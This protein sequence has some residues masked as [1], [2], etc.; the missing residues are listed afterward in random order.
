MGNKN[1]WIDLAILDLCTVGLL[2][3]LLRSK[4]VFALPFINYNHLLE[5]HS[6]FTFS[7][8]VTLVLM[9]LMVYELLP[10]S[11][12][13]KPSYQWLFA[14]IAISSWG[15]LIAFILQG[16]G[17]FSIIFSACFILFTY[18]FGWV[19]TRD[20]IKSKSG[21][22]VSLLAISSISCLIISSAGLSVIYYIYFTKSFEAI[23][24]RD[25]LFTYL[26][27]QY[28]GFFSLAIFALLFNHASKNI[29][30]KI[31]KNIHLFSV[32]FCLSIIP[33]L[34]L[35]YLWRDPNELFHAI[36]IGGSILLLLSCIL[37]IISARQFLATY[38]N[39]KPIVRFLAY[40]SM[41]SFLLKSFLQCFTIFP[42]IGNAIFGN[43]PI[44]MG[45]LHL[46]FL[47]FVS[48]F[49]LAYFS[50][51]GLLD[52][53]KRITRTALIVFAIAVILNE[54]ILIAQGLAT[55]FM[56]GSNI[57]PWMLWATGVCL[58]TGAILIAV[59]RIQTKP[60]I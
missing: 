30:S 16:Y 11:S 22:T 7:G 23:L 47:G 19:F 45:F 48:L 44:I 26:H 32:V 58:F 42:Q 31:Q 27:F 40:L 37:F 3:A 28:N 21:A 1:K 29:S 12:N 49:I 5:G 25:A 51:T 43:R 9:V 46:V 4:I 39:E 57:F 18:M 38:H 8:W 24:Y 54:A 55:V 2:G 56:P 34:F 6:H 59:A 33:S 60:M 20:I 13:K 15:M 35:S 10:A 52:C 17:A 41:G 36:A 53:T 50:K 14:G